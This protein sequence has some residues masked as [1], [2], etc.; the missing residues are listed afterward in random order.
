ML[1]SLPLP[2]VPPSCQMH[3]PPGPFS[4]GAPTAVSAVSASDSPTDSLRTP[5]SSSTGVGPA[6][7]ASSPSSSVPLAPVGSST[8]PQHHAVL[9]GN[10]TVGGARGGSGG[11]ASSVSLAFPKS[12]ASYVTSTVSPGVHGGGTAITAVPGS[13]VESAHSP[14][15]GGGVYQVGAGDA[16]VSVGAG[17]SAA[18]ANGERRT[19]TD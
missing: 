4:L 14:E 17:A 13:H 12:S 1:L 11:H 9:G 16:N 3:P 7:L 6:A 10:S 19:V 15:A 2:S 18:A 8:P 5:M